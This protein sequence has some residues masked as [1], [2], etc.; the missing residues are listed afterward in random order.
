V[1]TGRGAHGFDGRRP[2]YLGAYLV[3][4]KLL[5]PA[6]QREREQ[7]FMLAPSEGTGSLYGLGVE[8]QNGWIGHNGNISGYQTYAYYLPPERTTMVVIV[9]SSVDLIGVW[10]LVTEIVKIISPDHSWPA[11]PSDP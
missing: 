11:P 6:T 4:G 8:N 10:N 9:N 3:T 5:S 2:A 7:S 1:G